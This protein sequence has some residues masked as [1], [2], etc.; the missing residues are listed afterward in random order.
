VIH[1]VYSIYDIKALAFLQP[2]FSL[3]DRTACRAVGAVVNDA[4]TLLAKHPED[5]VLFH[6]GEYE[7]TKGL[8]SG[9]P[10]P[11]QVCMVA[12]LRDSSNVKEVSSEA[13]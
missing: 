9:K 4:G 12:V 7:D 1:N 6:V 13:A 2:F 3:N 10:V 8:L 5:F 11:T